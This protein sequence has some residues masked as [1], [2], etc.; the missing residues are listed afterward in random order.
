MNK[1]RLDIRV[2][3]KLKIQCKNKMQQ[4]FKDFNKK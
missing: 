2:N 4:D 1:K 3:L